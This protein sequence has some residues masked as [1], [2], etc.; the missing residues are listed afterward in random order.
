METQADKKKQNDLKFDRRAPILELFQL[1]AEQR[2]S[3]DRRRALAFA[4]LLLGT[5]LTIILI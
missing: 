5:P 2:Q 1:K 4:R 3:S